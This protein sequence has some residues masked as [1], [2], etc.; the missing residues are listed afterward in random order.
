[1]SSPTPAASPPRTS[2]GRRAARATRGT[3]ACWPSGCAAPWRAPSSPCGPAARCSGST[4]AGARSSLPSSA[5]R[6]P[7]RLAASSPRSSLLG[8]GAPNLADSPVMASTGVLI[9]SCPDQP[10]IIAAVASFVACYGGNVIELQQHTDDT[11]GAFFQRAEFEL[12]HLDQP[13]DGI[14]GAVD[15]A[16][17]PKSVLPSTM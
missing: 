3:R 15:R 10:G 1:M 8:A 4:C 11:G 9:V 2:S 14:G 16:V 13:A 5:S 6:P 7:S 12:E 17:A